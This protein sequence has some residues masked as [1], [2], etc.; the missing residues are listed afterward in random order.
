M[1]SF[2]KEELFEKI[3]QVAV[4]AGEELIMLVF[5]LFYTLIDSK[6]S[7]SDRILIVSALVYFISPMDAIPDAIIGLGY[8]DDLSILVATFTSIASL[9]TVEISAMAR[10]RFD[11]WFGGARA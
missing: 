9:V 10:E 2:S 11:D 8:T 7:V 6:T 5:K 3:K 1:N 4:S